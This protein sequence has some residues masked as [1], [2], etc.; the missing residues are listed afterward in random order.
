M[1]NPIT[2]E[3]ADDE[4]RDQRNLEGSLRA[5]TPSRDLENPLSQ[6]KEQW[7]SDC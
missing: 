4:G 3:S 1:K 2:P 6:E 7:R 5:A